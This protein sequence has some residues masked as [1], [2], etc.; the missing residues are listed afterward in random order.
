MSESIEREL[1]AISAHLKNL[2]N[3]VEKQ[4]G[5]LDSM[6]ARLRKVE[7]KGA[8]S[9]AITGGMMAL[10]IAFIKDSFKS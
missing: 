8:V 9:G 6:D 5:T 1:G 2:N 10:A 7:T 3:K 4:C